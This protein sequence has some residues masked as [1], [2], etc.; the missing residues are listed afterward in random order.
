MTARDLVGEALDDFLRPS[1][2]RDD[3]SFVTARSVVEES[4]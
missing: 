2:A 3:G 4:P 1:A